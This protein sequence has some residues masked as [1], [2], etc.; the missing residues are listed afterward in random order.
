MPRFIVTKTEI[1]G[2]CRKRWGKDWHKC[3]PA[4]KK[5]RVVWAA[6]GDVEG[7]TVRV[8]DESGTY[9]A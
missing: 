8:T 7:R 6:G 2:A 1:R 3:H 9:A 4:I 5:A